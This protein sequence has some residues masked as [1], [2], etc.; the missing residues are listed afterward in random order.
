MSEQQLHISVAELM[1][2]VR[3]LEAKMDVV[4]KQLNIE[5]VDDSQ[6][7]YLAEVSA[8]VAMGKMI[9]AI[10][11]YRANTGADLAAAKAYVEGLPKPSK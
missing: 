1:H 10:K 5:F 3:L 11:V 4:L 8:L 6:Q 9:D 2:R 7:G